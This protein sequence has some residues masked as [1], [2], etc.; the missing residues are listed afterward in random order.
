VISSALTNLGEA[1]EKVLAR[2]HA[3]LQRALTASEEVHQLTAVLDQKALARVMARSQAEQLRQA[4]R[5]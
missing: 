5:E 3:D 2:H 4:R 1:L